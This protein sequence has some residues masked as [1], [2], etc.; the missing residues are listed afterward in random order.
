MDFLH[1][2]QKKE[3][4]IFNDLKIDNPLISVCVVTYQHAQFI[5]QCLDGILMQQTNFAFEILLGDDEST[6]G[7]REICIE[8][9]K[10]YPNKIRLFL[11]HRENN[12]AINGNP[13][14]R[15]N[16]MY[17]LYNA[18]GKYIALCEGDDYWTDPLKLQKQVDFLETNQ[19]FV[20]SCHNSNIINSDGS[21]N[22]LFNKNGI[23]ETTDTNYI[24]RNSW[25]MPTAS[26]VFNKSNL[27]IPKWYHRVINGDYVLYLILTASGGLVGYTSNCMCAYR[28][29]NQGASNVFSRANLYSYSMLFINRKF[30]SYSKGKYFK[31]IKKNI[32]EFSFNILNSIPVYSKDFLRVTLKL[33]WVNRG[34][35][36]NQ[37]KSIFEIII[38]NKI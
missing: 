15:F 28:L 38:Q 5:S 34:L 20:I 37:A 30:N 2:F 36:F 13:T 32:W 23:P 14:G 8:Y 25:Y 27:I 6:D 33:I 18:R 35:T 1:R 3:V 10:K 29:H 17:N 19:K 21:F 24:L 11:H 12:I 9:A 7:T 26:V 16:F 31:A 4:H 22:K